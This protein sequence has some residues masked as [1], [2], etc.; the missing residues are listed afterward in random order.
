MRASSRQGTERCAGLGVGQTCRSSWKID[1]RPSQAPALRHVAIRSG[2]STRWQRWLASQTFSCSPSTAPCRAVGTHHR[3]V[4]VLVVLREPDDAMR[5]VVDPKALAHGVGEDRAEQRRRCGR[6][7]HGHHARPRDHAA[8]SSPGPA[9]MPAATS[10][11]KALRHRS[12]VIAATG[13]RPSSGMMWR[14]IR[15][16][17]EISVNSFWRILRRVRSRPASTSARYCWQSSATVIAS[18]PAILSA[19]GIGTLDH[20]AKDAPGFLACR[21][22]RPGRSMLADR[23]GALPTFLG[24]V[25]D[26]VGDDRTVLPARR[27]AA[28]RPVPNGLA[29]LKK[30]EIAEAGLR[31]RRSGIAQPR[32]R[33]GDQIQGRSTKGSSP[34]PRQ[35]EISP[36]KKAPR[37]Q[38]IAPPVNSRQARPA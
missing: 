15:P 16:R 26:D 37:R 38:I 32:I 29:W 23:I 6:R 28:N 1:L 7:R 25:H 34:D 22:G 12:G 4:V 17:S 13:I 14:S 11:M 20:F 21:I 10:C 33:R 2:P 24:P 5:R 35:L 3:S 36:P 30:A 18:R 27:Q 8:S 31:P 9:V 19:I